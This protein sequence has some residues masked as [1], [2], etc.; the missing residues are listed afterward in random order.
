MCKD[1][2]YN[3]QGGRKTSLPAGLTF[4][5]L[6]NIGIK[7]VMSLVPKIKLHSR[8]TELRFT[9]FLIFMITSFDMGPFMI[10]KP[11]KLVQLILNESDTGF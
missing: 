1:Y 7:L 2:Y 11:T 8:V 4:G 9:V 6:N 10:I 3:L 5:I